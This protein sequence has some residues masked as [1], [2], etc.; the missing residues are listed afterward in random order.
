[1]N[2]QDFLNA[3]LK[4]DA[5]CLFSAAKIA[6]LKNTAEFAYRQTSLIDVCAFRAP[7]QQSSRI[8]ILST[9]AF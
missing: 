9:V 4:Q 1:M 2:I 5:E 6:R 3:V 7:M 8:D